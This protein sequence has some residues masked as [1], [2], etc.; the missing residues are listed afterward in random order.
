MLKSPNSLTSF[1]Y[2][3]MTFRVLIFPGLSLVNAC[4]WKRINY[5]V[6]TPASRGKLPKLNF[7]LR[8]LLSDIEQV[9]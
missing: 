5:L 6:E 7:W 2:Y 1:V 3:S 8:H 9:I 4:V